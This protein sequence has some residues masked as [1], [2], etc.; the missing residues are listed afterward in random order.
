MPDLLVNGRI[1]TMDPTTPSPEALLTDGERV[2]F[3]GRRAEAETIA[4]KLTCVRQV[5][6]RGHRVIP[7]LIDMHA[8]LDRE[9][10]KRLHAPMIGLHSRH[11]VLNRIAELAR[12]A[13]PG[14]WI[15]TS[16]LGEPPFYFFGDPQLEADLYPTRW[17]LDEVAPDNP[18]YIRPIIG[19]WRWSPW[20]ERLVSAANSAAMHLAELGDS[21]APPSPS[22]ELER[23]SKGRLTGRFFERTTVSILELVHFAKALRYSDG[24]RLRALELSQHIALSTGTTT[25]FEGHGVE[26][27]VMRA[28]SALHDAGRM[29][30]RAE[31]AFSPNWTGA[32]QA[33]ESHV[34]R[35]LKWLGG[36]GSGDDALRVCG[37]FVNPLLIHDDLVRSNAGYTG[38]AGYHFGSGL[39]EAAMLRMLKALAANEI[40][41]VGLTSALFA[42]FDRVGNEI[43]IRRLGWLIQHCGH[44]PPQ[45]AE[46]AARYKLG[47]SFLPVEASYKQAVKIRNDKALAADFM[48]LR[49]LLEAGQPISIASDNIPPSLFF[50]IWCCLARRDYR[51]QVLPDPDGPIS[52][53]EA[54]RIATVEAARCLDRSDKLGS[55]SPGKYADLAVLDRDFFACALDD[56]PNIAALATMVGGRWRHGDPDRL[57]EL[58]PQE[59]KVRPC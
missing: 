13:T 30:M 59:A 52:R 8:H 29:A 56:I 51:G 24:D 32:S 39:A 41:A 4:A 2:L 44:L 21:A 12:K 25:V 58:S 28:Y 9:G 42:L 40:R 35:D 43:D 53:E 47:L 50:A 55:L 16:P 10:L 17:Q 3:I 57:P 1:S 36:K 49:R 46:I 31:L 18:V 23:D 48:P 22:V 37:I 19:F 54:L 34:E 45:H 15:V 11:E 20:P 27:A 5:D 38:M 6:L 33:I 14:A 7:G 26:P